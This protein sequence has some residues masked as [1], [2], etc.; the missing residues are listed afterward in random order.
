VEGRTLRAEF[1]SGR[2]ARQMHPT[3]RWGGKEDEI[4]LI[5]DTC[6][7]FVIVEDQNSQN[8]ATR[9]T[10]MRD[11]T[12]LGNESLRNT[13]YLKSTSSRQGAFGRAM[14]KDRT[15]PRIN[16]QSF[17]NLKNITLTNMEHMRLIFMLSL[18]IPLAEVARATLASEPTLCLLA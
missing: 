17:L 6:R 4:H 16:R 10:V 18:T 1:R 11:K 13:A 12:S 9:L 8:I 7:W 2:P 15:A 14:P 5:G 3:V